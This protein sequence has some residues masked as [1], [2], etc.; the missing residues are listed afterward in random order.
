MTKAEACLWKFVLRAGQMKGYTFNRQRPV[1]RYIADF[2]CKPLNLIIEVDG[3]SHDNLKVQKH[4]AFRQSEL[5]TCGFKVL[6]FSND[7]VL[8]TIDLVRKSILAK[9]NQIEAAAVLTCRKRRR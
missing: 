5:E 2:I 4:D 1:L 6:R 9:I 3:S 7:Q 8:L